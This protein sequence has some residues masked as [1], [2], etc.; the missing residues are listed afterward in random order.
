LLGLSPI[1]QGFDMTRYYLDT[2]F[3]EDGHTID[4]I[5]IGIVAEDGREFYAVNKGC[6]FSKADDWVKENVISHL[7]PRPRLPMECTPRE[8]EESLAWKSKAQITVDVAA[9]LKD[10][11]P[12]NPGSAAKQVRGLIPSLLTLLGIRDCS[13][14]TEQS[15]RIL[16]WESFQ[17]PEIWAYYADYDWVAFCQLFGAMID[18][19]AGFPMYCRDLQ[20]EADRLGVDLSK[21]PQTDE[22]HALADARW[23]KAAHEY[24]M[25]YEDA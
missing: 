21:L 20:Q 25:K 9:F 7:P 22:H 18:L 13:E 5:S 10:L 12:N 24:L 14:W 15:L 16:H 2:E 3:I 4:L 17:A 11:T 19:P 6:D 8:W 1:A 23:T